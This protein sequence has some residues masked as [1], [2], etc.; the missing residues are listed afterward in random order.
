MKGYS[1]REAPPENRLTVGPGH[2]TLMRAIEQV[3]LA[4]AMGEHFQTNFLRV[5][6]DRFGVN[7]ITH[8]ADG[9]I[10]TLVEIG[11]LPFTQIKDNPLPIVYPVDPFAS[12][13]APLQGTYPTLLI[14]RFKDAVAWARIITPGGGAHFTTRVGSIRLGEDADV[15]AVVAEI[16]SEAFKIVED[17]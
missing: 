17:K 4:N 6:P 9:K 3:K 7:F 10:K 13:P 12:I 14:V 8:D 1:G 11:D 16:P 2:L 5:S 15:K